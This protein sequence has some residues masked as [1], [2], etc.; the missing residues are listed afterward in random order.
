MFKSIAAALLALVLRPPACAQ[1][2]VV[3]TA[4]VPPATCKAYSSN[5]DWSQVAWLRNVEVVV[6]D[7]KSF[8]EEDQKLTQLIETRIKAAK[9]AGDMN[10]AGSTKVGTDVFPNILMEAEAG[11]I[12]KIFISTDRHATIKGG[13]GKEITLVLPDD[14]DIERLSDELLYYLMGYSQGHLMGLASTVP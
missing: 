2:S 8:K 6:A 11:I 12:R 4:D 13:D 1:S 3:C 14:G 9:T 10:R 7:P 5:M